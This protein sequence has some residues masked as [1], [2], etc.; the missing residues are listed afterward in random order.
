MG[1]CHV[2]ICRGYPSRACLAYVSSRTAG[3]R[4]RA[5]TVYLA[6]LWQI[7]GDRATGRMH[8]YSLSTLSTP[9]LLSTLRGI[10]PEQYLNTFRISAT[11]GN[12]DIPRAHADALLT[13]TLRMNTL[14]PPLSLKAVF[15]HKHSLA[16]IS[17]ATI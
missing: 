17:T 3:L 6:G 13:L 11:L 12:R 10:A 7:W 14:R 1:I 5:R 8:E 9:Q 15:A 4:G 16:H 2:A